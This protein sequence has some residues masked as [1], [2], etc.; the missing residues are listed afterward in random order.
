MLGVL[1]GMSTMNSCK[2]LY[3]SGGVRRFYSGLSA[4][5]MQ[6]PLSR[7]GDTA[8]NAA[9]INILESSPATR[10]LPVVVQTFAGSAVAAAWRM[11]IMPL[12]VCKTI[13]Q[14]HGSVGMVELK[15]RVQQHGPGVLWR[16]SSAAFGATLCG[17]LPWYSTF[18]FLNRMLPIYGDSAR[19]PGTSSRSGTE[20]RGAV[21]TGAHKVPEKGTA[22]HG[23]YVA[24]SG[25]PPMP[26]TIATPARKKYINAARHGLIG[27]CS[28]VISDCCTNSLRVMKAIRQ[29]ENVSYRTAATMVVEADGLIGLFGRGLQTRLVANG[30]QGLVFTALWKAL[31][32]AISERRK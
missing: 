14:M 13:A 26:D 20:T 17:H 11:V 16:G 4:A 12:D 31:E 3:S 22:A 27:F 19:L 5:L 23:P 2:A 28:S 18:N 9:I 6:G 8:S 7:F 25:M 1:I 29:S 24:N 15:N 21:G 30:C 10:S 32:D